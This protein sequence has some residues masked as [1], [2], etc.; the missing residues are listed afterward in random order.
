L[1]HF[2]KKD[3]HFYFFTEK[4]R[5]SLFADQQKES[6]FMRQRPKNMIT[7]KLGFIIMGILLFSIVIIFISMYKTN[8]TEIQKAAGVEAYGCAN[9]TTALVKPADIE[10]II[11]GDKA[12]S[13]KVGKDI[14]W[15]VQHKDIFAGQYIMDTSGKLL[16]VDENLLNQGFHPEDMFQIS[17]KD[18]EHLLAARAPVYSD[19]YKFG[20]MKRLTGYAPI[21]KDHDPEKEIIAVS[22]IDFESSIV[23]TRTWDMIKGSFLFAIIP[24][25][26][27]GFATIYLIKKTTEPRIRSSLLPAELQ[28]AI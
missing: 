19:V 6:L 21:F 15:T 20:G 11:S 12:A 7:R 13:E 25:I 23:H 18:L 24:I 1:Y 27:A 4:R 16:A 22:A 28:M 3:K 9:I 8:Y 5:V 17:P 26:L 10:K 14:S 2:L